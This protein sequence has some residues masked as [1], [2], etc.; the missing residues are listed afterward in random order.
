MGACPECRLSIV[1][2]LF[3][4]C[5]YTVIKENHGDGVSNRIIKT[6]RDKD[7]IL[8][9]SMRVRLQLIMVSIVQLFYK[10][11]IVFLSRTVLF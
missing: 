5:R 4:S 8:I 11:L 6:Q 9:R 3:S 10:I 7:G 1:T 2:I